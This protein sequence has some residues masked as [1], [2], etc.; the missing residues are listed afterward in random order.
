MN[1]N[2]FGIPF[3]G[4]D[5]CG[6][7][8]NTNEELCTRWMQLGALYP[9]AR[10]HHEN[11]T[12]HQEPYSFGSTLLHASHTALK[13]RYSLLKYYYSLFLDRNGLGTVMR[14]LFFEFPNEMILYDE[15]ND[16]V[17]EQFMIGSALMVAPVLRSGHTNVSTFFPAGTWYDYYTGDI[18]LNNTENATEK[19]IQARLSM[20]IPLFLRGGYIVPSQLTNDVLATVDLDNRYILT[21]GLYPVDSINYAATGM[22]IGINKFTDENIV[23][24]CKE[25]N[26]VMDIYARGVRGNHIKLK[27]TPRDRNNEFEEVS[28]I[29]IRF[30]GLDKPIDS[31]KFSVIKNDLPLKGATCTLNTVNL[32]DV[33]INP[34]DGLTIYI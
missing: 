16:Y 11:F 21:I 1:S 32:P 27:F 19:V 8:K 14:P 23:R 34:F 10:N 22:L 20:S 5:I 15:E 12:R 7:A 3:V 25:R 4:A 18:L 6:F 28:L 29:E 13:L 31:T 9:F 30:Y 2:I 24:K 26:C 33:V 17:E